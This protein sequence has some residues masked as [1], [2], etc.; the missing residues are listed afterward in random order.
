MNIIEGNLKGFLLLILILYGCGEEMKEIDDGIVLPT[1]DS[2]RVSMYSYDEKNRVK[3]V[4]RGLRS[5]VY[6]E[7]QE[8]WLDDIK[9][10]I[11][12]Y[13]EMGG[14][15]RVELTANEGRV[16]YESLDFEV[17]GDGLIVRE[18]EVRIEGDR[19]YWDN[20]RKYFY[21]KDEELV[22]IYRLMKGEDGGVVIARGRNLVAKDEL[23]TVELD[24][25]ETGVPKLLLE[26]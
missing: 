12:D 23:K 4:I 7:Q 10:L 18:E 17:W 19:F 14:L 25:V 16:N 1:S 24:E 13:E 6:K 5:V 11:L 21:T 3:I 8:I 15:V 9:V 2:E 20:E 26:E 22:K